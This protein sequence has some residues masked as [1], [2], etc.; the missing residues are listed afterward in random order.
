[1]SARSFC[2]RPLAAAACLTA[3]VTAL[4]ACGSDS[5]AVSQ[6]TTTAAPRASSSAD[7]SDAGSPRP[8][9]TADPDAD[10]K[11]S[12]V[13]SGFGVAGEYAWVAALVRN[14]SDK[15]GAT[16]IVNFNL[17]DA[18]GA[19]IVS[20]SQTE[21]FSRPGQ[22]LALGTQVDVPAG[23]KPTKLEATAQVAYP[24]IGPSGPFPDLPFGPVTVAKDEFGGFVASAE[25]TNPTAEALN[26]PRIGVVCLDAAGA[27]IG[28]SS[29]FP[30]LVPPRGRVKVET[31]SL[32]TTVQPVTCEMYA[33]APL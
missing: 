22:V 28:G 27:I 20:G 4:S 24:G 13:K 17:L 8:A 15:S 19:I 10:T 30:D 3:V 23:A 16:V 18:A 21:A 1:M 11:H 2:R 7:G 26:S 12:L 14:D 9:E 29:I 33:G 31:L 32:I 25:L 5:S 6:Q